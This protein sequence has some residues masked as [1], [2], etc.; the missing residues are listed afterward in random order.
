M[1]IFRRWAQRDML[2]FDLETTGVDRFS[3]LPVSFALIW[4]RRGRVRQV[5]ASLVDPGREIP[6]GATAVHGISTA[7]AKAEGLPLADAVQQ[8]ADALLR[9]SVQQVP[10]VGMKLD[11]DLT[12]I[13][14]LYRQLH[15]RHLEDDGFCGPVI[16]A[17][18]LDRHYDR[19]RKGKRTLSDL[20]GHYGV[21]IEHAHDASSDA[22]ATV[23]IV[24]AMCRRYPMLRRTVPRALHAAQVEWH[25]EW[26]ESFDEW[27]RRKGLAPLG[28]HDDMW[29]VAVC[30]EHPGIALDVAI[31]SAS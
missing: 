21:T 11:F 27:R 20:C 9:A 10:I 19:Y 30:P 29:P 12:M 2:A 6:A 28:M 14:A 15:G 24:R 22:L 4:V 25:R 26:A 3:D 5:Q 16:D 31:A 8:V 17:L 7:R 23:G 18:V 1:A 13:D